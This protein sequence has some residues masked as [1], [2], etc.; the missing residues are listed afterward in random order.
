LSD[1]GVPPLRPTALVLM[2]EYGGVFLWNRSP[3][4]SGPGFYI[5]DPVELGVS[6]A[7]VERMAAWNDEWEEM[8]YSN[9]GFASPEVEQ[10]WVRR[11]WELAHEL[12]DQLPDIQVLYHH[13]PRGERPVRTG[14]S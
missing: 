13:D 14:Q 11:G 9:V 12:Q 2:A 8:A 6:S 7:L 5:L 1:D 4:P 10:A 3:D